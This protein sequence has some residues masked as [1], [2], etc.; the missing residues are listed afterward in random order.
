MFLHS[1][2]TAASAPQWVNPSSP[3]PLALQ[4]QD[5]FLVWILTHSSRKAREKAN[6]HTHT[7]PYLS[8]LYLSLCPGLNQGGQRVTRNL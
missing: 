4:E 6:R 8:E 3:P 7:P 1:L 5:T 2:H